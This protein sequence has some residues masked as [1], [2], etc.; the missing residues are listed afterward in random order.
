M[1]LTNATRNIFGEGRLT[2][3]TKDGSGRVVTHLHDIHDL[4]WVDTYDRNG[5]AG[6]DFNVRRPDLDPS[7]R[8]K[9]HF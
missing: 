7:G 5:F 8:P 2:Q 4:H 1:P 6:T 9:P 3:I